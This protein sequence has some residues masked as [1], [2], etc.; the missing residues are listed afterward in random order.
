MATG[1]RA[2]TFPVSLTGA[3]LA[4]TIAALRREKERLQL[5]RAHMGEHLPG[6]RLAIDRIDEIDAQIARIRKHARATLPG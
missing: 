6:G 2:M 1:E 4:I 5:Y 3:A